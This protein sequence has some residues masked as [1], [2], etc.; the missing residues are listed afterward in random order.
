V[1]PLKS[2]SNL[3]GWTQG[4]VK[5]PLKAGAHLTFLAPSTSV[6]KLPAGPDYTAISADWQRQ[7]HATQLALPDKTLQNAYYA[8]LGYIVADQHAGVI[9]PGPLLHNRFWVRD[10]ALIGYALERAS[11]SGSVTATAAATLRAIGSNGEVVSVTDASGKPLPYAE[12]DAAGEAVFGLTEYARYSGDQAFLRQTFPAIT[13]VLRHAM[14]ALDEW[15]LV[16]PNLSAEDLGAASQHHYWDDFWL[17][18]GLSDAQWAAQRLDQPA[19]A[20]EF[21]R[22]TTQL[23]QSLLASI[24]A[25]RVGYIPDGPEDLDSSAMA[26]GSS[27]ALWPTQVLDPTS[28]LVLESFDTYYQRL[29]APDDGAYHHLFGQWWPYG[30]LELAHDLLFLGQRDRMQQIL[31]YTL[32]H[33][34]APGLFAW[35][36]G[37]DP[38]TNGFAEGDMPHAWAAAE[39]VSLVRDS[40][41]YEDGERL[42]VGAGVP[43][44]WQGQPFSAHGMPTTWGKADLDV[45]ADGVVQVT[46]IS[47]PGGVTLDLPFAARLASH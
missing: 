42:V 19:M 23:R 39:V 8:S 21:A 16:P 11:L 40:L 18:T 24:S 34:T 2:A 27:V 43:A 26:R 3:G 1:P 15:G 29:I 44:R 37:V 5:A 36:E 20:A 9:E 6:A 28:P 13:Q 38:R 31:T 47:P 46:G 17:L 12:L 35:A 7:L 25:T 22:D 32:Q 4:L 45:A 14:G 41:L 10:A 33:Q 30:G